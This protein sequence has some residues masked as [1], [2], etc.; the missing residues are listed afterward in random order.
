MGFSLK[1]AWDDI[2]GQSAADDAAKA[3]GKATDAS[4]ALQRESRDLARNDLAPYA[5]MGKATLPYLN[6]MIAGSKGS[7]GIDGSQLE[8]LATAEGTKDFLENDPLL[9]YA[10][11]EATRGMDAATAATGKHGSG[12]HAKA[13]RNSLY[14]LAQNR[15]SDRRG[16]LS[17]IFS[18]KF[19]LKSLDNN[20]WD[21]KLNSLFRVA[22]MGQNS[23]AG[24]GAVSQN[25]TNQ[26]T[27]LLT[28]QGNADAAA[29]VAGHNNIMNLAN[30]ALGATATYYGAKA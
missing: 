9:A 13:L 27:N 1:G 10:T 19:N 7:S 12:G 22:T 30:T 15:L 11:G 8:N 14:D 18:Q 26:M 4:L 5:D 16:E 21:N 23:A 29:A 24:Q 20:M 6:Y 17:D 25:S 28:N 2:S 3:Q